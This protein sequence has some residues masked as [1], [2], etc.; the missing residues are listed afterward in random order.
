VVG[1]E[2]KKGSTRAIKALS[3]KYPLSDSCRTK[4]RAGNPGAWQRQAENF[5]SLNAADFRKG[6]VHIT[7]IDRW[8]FV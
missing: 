2:P 5:G 6:S 4:L 1:H 8:R 3:S 7:G